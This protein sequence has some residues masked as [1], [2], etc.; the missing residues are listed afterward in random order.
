MV[1][2]LDYHWSFL[3]ILAE[4]CAIM[5]RIIKLAGLHLL[6]LNHADQLYIIL[7]AN[8]MLADIIRW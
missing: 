5:E 2:L 7:R 6:R 3:V 1:V 8:Y 4:S